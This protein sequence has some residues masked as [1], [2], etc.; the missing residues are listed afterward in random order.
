MFLTFPSLSSVSAAV[1]ETKSLEKWLNLAYEVLEVVNEIG[2]PLSQPTLN[3]SQQIKETTQILAAAQ[4]L[5]VLNVLGKEKSLSR[6]FLFCYTLLTDLKLAGKWGFIQLGRI[7]QPLKG[8]LSYLKCARMAF[9][10]L[11][12][13][14]TALQTYNNRQFLKTALYIGK[15]TTTL[16]ETAENAFKIENKK[17]HLASLLLSFSVDTLACTT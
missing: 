8:D 6:F 4:T 2:F 12:C 7:K 11:Y 3:L 5:S 15:L 9:Y 16:L 1:S 13:L 17:Y 10:S 14:F